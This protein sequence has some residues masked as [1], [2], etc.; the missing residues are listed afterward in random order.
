MLSTTRL[1]M[2]RLVARGAMPM[3][4]QGP[5]DS[6][7][8]AFFRLGKN[9]VLAHRAETNCDSETNSTFSV[10]RLRYLHRPQQRGSDPHNLRHEALTKKKKKEKAKI[11]E[12]RDC[13]A[14]RVEV[15]LEGDAANETP[16]GVLQGASAGH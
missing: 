12:E 10:S 13:I 2:L 7:V 9:H 15:E 1:V 3:R 8:L 5:Q 16:T 14:G 11:K 4:L 6:A